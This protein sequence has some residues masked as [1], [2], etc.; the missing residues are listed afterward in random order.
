M[1][2]PSKEKPPAEVAAEARRLLRGRGVSVQVLG[3]AQLREQRLGGLLGVG[4]GSEQTPRFLKLS[5]TPT[6]GARPARGKTL[7]FVGKGVVF[8]SGGLSLKPG[9]HGDDEM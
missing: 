4:Q 8:D 7:A 2:R 6:G 1:N 9:R 3:V 5:Y